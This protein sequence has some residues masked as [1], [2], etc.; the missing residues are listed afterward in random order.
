MHLSINVSFF[1]KLLQKLSSS[2]VNH[3]HTVIFEV[4]YNEF[5][6]VTNANERMIQPTGPLSPNLNTGSPST[7]N[8]WILLFSY[9]APTIKRPSLE[10]QTLV[11]ILNSP[12]PL[13]CFPKLFTK[14][15]VCTF[16]CWY[17]VITFI[18]HQNLVIVE[19]CD[20]TIAS[21]SNLHLCVQ[22]N[23]VAQTFLCH[24]KPGYRDHPNQPRQ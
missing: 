21:S 22:D 7:V 20:V 8:T 2:L 12:S 13:P 15:P 18:Y 19:E 5:V 3:F 1:S 9:S 10:I 4:S 23:Q 11:G 16:H 17:S 14:F 6:R 24:Q